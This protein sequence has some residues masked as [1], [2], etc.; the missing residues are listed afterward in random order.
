MANIKNVHPLSAEKLFDLLKKEFP[1]YI[2]QRLGSELSIDFAHVY[3]VINVMFPE[4]IEGAVFSV[5]VNDD[6]IT[7]SGDFDSPEYN[8]ALLE[9]ELTDFIALKAS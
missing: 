6:E 1:D 4:V 7:I 2:N 9:K 3:D 8:K 5:T